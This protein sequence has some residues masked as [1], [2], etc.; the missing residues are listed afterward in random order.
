MNPNVVA[1]RVWHYD[2]MNHELW[3]VGGDTAATKRGGERVDMVKMPNRGM[4]RVMREAM[5]IAREEHRV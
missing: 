2:Y 3:W 4:F 1:R 5:R